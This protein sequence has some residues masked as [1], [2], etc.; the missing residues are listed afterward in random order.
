MTELLINVRQIFVEGQIIENIT[1]L[2]KIETCTQLICVFF[3]KCVYFSSNVYYFEQT[4]VCPICSILWFK[5]YQAFCNFACV[6]RKTC[7]RIS[8]PSESWMCNGHINASID[9]T[10]LWY[11]N[12]FNFTLSSRPPMPVK[13]AD[14]NL[15]YLQY[16]L[17]SCLLN[18]FFSWM[19]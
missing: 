9:W 12:I 3:A 1:K 18:R 16:I 6:L 10:R 14:D 13:I 5:K 11:V 2:N 8:P 7:V 17:I 19:L 4:R 15:S